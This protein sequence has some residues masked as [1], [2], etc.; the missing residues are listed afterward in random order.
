M[1][2]RRSAR[3]SAVSLVS[4]A[5]I[6]AS[7]VFALPAHAELN[8]ALAPSQN[9][10]LTHWKLT[11]PSGSEVQASQL[12]AG[13][14]YAGQFYTNPAN[15]GM[16]FRCP[17]I[18]GTTTNSHYS[19]SEL[20][21]MLDPSG[22]SSTSDANNWT[23]ADGGT[24]IARVRVDRVSTTGDSSKVGRVVIGQ[25]H[26]PDTEVIRLYYTK[27]P[28]EAT[29]RIYAGMDSIENDNTYSPD[30]VSNKSGAGIPLGQPFTYVIKLYGLKLEV[31]I[32]TKDRVVHRYIK[33]VDPGYRGENLYFKAG[34][35][36]QNNTGDKSDYVQATFFR[37][38]HTH[39]TE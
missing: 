7:A 22:S 16:T 17:N 27:L 10:D 19:R 25:I 29:G 32:I 8:R 5:L 26:G 14:Q 13:Y 38:T 4:S 9:F 15:G 37:L 35:Y 36:N 21:E 31:K 23:T 39:P 3:R 20:R 6:A 33:Y 28:N 34:V 24:M 11:L 12:N 2:F 30:I 18:A 1:Y